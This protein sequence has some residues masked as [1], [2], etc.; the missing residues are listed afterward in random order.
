MISGLAHLKGHQRD[1]EPA[2]VMVATSNTTL[3][4]LSTHNITHYNRSHSAVTPATPSLQGPHRKPLSRTIA[5][6]SFLVRT[7]RAHKLFPVQSSTT[8]SR[9]KHDAT[10]DF[11]HPFT[12]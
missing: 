1:L 12:T 10:L 2:G 9:S 6:R 5:R 7:G 11:Y 4:P 8:P 3:Q